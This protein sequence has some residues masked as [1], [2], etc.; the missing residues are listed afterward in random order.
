MDGV[1][2]EIWVDIKPFNGQY[3]VSNFGRVRSLVFK[4]R[5][6]NK[7]RKEPMLL[8][9]KSKF[10]YSRIQLGIKSY[11][12]HRLVLENFVGACPPNMECAHLDGNRSNCHLDNLKWV[13]KKENHS[14]KKLHGTHQSGERSGHSKLSLGNVLEIR[15]LRSKG[16]KLK[17]LAH[18]YKV[19]E[20]N[21]SSICNYKT[22]TYDAPKSG[23]KNG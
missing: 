12:V 9:F 6:T 22:W 4:N 23:V 7:P 13:T 19:S 5:T 15:D 2:E 3:Q 20:T 1:K 16:L 8:K 10:G 17:E 18:K 11:F 21:I 14:H